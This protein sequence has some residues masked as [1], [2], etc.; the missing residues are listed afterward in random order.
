MR[1]LLATYLHHNHRER[2]NIR[3]LAH[4]P[5]PVHDLRCGPAR[6]V[7]MRHGSLRCNFLIP[8]EA[9]IC[10]TR[11]TKIINQNIGLQGFNE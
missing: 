11:T 5:F 8:G 9:E 10:D 7:T 6:S 1:Q 3:F 2:K 4:R